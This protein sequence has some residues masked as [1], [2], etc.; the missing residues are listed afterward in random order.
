MKKKELK[1]LQQINLEKIENIKRH[2]GG[3]SESKAVRQIFSRAYDRT[4]TMPKKMNWLE[5]W[6]ICFNDEINFFNDNYRTKW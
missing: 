1:F 5:K 4:A 2:Y 6:A 3:Y